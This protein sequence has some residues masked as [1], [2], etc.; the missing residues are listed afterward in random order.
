MKDILK[1]YRKKKN[2]HNVWIVLTSLALWFWINALIFDDWNIWNQLKTNVTE[3]VVKEIQSDLYIEQNNDFYSIKVW[4]D[5][6]N[7]ENISFS[8]AYNPDNIRISS[9]ESDDDNI[10]IMN[11]SNQPWINTVVINLEKPSD[12]NKG[13]EILKLKVKKEN[14]TPESINLINWNFT[15]TEWETY[16][17]STSGVEL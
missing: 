17:F 16:L 9:I 5:M 15:D 11:L 1:K 8:L 4:M 10:D 7:V 12:I 6:K 2:I 13:E 14:N 3:A